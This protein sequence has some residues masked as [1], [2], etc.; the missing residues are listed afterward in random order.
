[1]KWDVVF[2]PQNL[3]LYGEGVVTTLAL[4]FSSLAVGGLLALF[5]AIALTE[6]WSWLRRVVGLYTYVMRG[7]PL[8]IQVYLIYYGLG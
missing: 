6:R 5:M 3:A 4:L 1:M 8:L 7:T 2:Q